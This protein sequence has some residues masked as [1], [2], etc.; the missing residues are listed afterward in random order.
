MSD[1]NK[2]EKQPR[3]ITKEEENAIGDILERAPD[4]RTHTIILLA[5]HRGFNLGKREE[6]S[7][8]EK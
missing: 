3:K 6:R 2:K 4:D 1:N 5:Y 7:K 8:W